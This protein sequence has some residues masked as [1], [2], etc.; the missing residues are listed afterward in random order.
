MH[1]SP[2]VFPSVLLHQLVSQARTLESILSP[3]LPLTPTP[4]PSTSHQSPNSLFL[5]GL[6]PSSDL[7]CSFWSYH[8]VLVS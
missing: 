3:S 7:V 2:L 4:P 1:P 8:K 6:S 5:L